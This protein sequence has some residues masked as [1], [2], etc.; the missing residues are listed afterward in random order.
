M[1]TVFNPLSYLTGLLLLTIIG[2]LL[3]YRRRILS[4]R[5]Q[6]QAKSGI[7]IAGIS[8]DVSEKTDFYSTREMALIEEQLRIV[9]QTGRNYLRPRYSIRDLSEETKIPVYKLSAY[10][11]QCEGMNFNDYIN[12]LRIGYC[13]ELITSGSAE[14]L[15]LKGLAAEC[16][17]SNRN[18]FTIAFKKFAGYNPS[19]YVK[20]KKL[21]GNDLSRAAILSPIMMLTMHVVTLIVV[22]M[23]VF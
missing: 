21:K 8:D 17:F 11:N 12:R 5:Q 23:I 6:K 7:S 10:V 4:R 15:N 22:I 2:L 18:T 19:E 9:L 3:V 14:G 1:N 20:L 16:G 13:I